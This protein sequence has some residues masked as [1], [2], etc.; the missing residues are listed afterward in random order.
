MNRYP[1]LVFALACVAGAPSAQA[2]ITY[3]TV[4]V[5]AAIGHGGNLFDGYIRANGSDSSLAAFGVPPG[6]ANPQGAPQQT[7]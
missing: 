6:F 7:R 2:L 3:H 5:Q 4:D 1:P